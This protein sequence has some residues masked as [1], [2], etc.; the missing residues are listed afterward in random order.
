M[1]RTFLLSISL[2]LLGTISFAQ[3]SKNGAA[4]PDPNKKTM[5]VET[6]CGECN[7]G[8]EGKSCDLAVKINGKAYFVDGA[9]INDF[10]NPHDDNGFCL[11]V[12]K[13][14]VQGEVVKNRF[15]ATYFKLLPVEATSK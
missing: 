3:V 13:A 10:G 9:K 14:E 8:L 7:F 5:T 12:R 15:K 6:S 2:C 4:K 1:I 11:A